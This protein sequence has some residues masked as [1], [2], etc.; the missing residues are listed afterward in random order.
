MLLLAKIK[1]QYIGKI[2]VIKGIERVSP[3]TQLQAYT[4]R[5]IIS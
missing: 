5:H 4:I 2:K 1:Q 3:K